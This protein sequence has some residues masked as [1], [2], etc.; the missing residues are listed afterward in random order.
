MTYKT[1]VIG[2]GSWGT[3]LAAHLARSARPEDT[4][5]LWGRDPKAI[6]TMQD[7]GINERYLPSQPLPEN[8]AYSCDLNQATTNVEL[9]VI[10]TPCQHFSYLLATLNRYPPSVRY[11]VWACKGMHQGRFP[12]DMFHAHNNSVQLG[13]D[14][15]SGAVISGPS[16]AGELVEGL[17]TATTIAANTIS[18]A[19]AVSARFHSDNFRAYSSDD[20]IGVQMA[21]AFKNVYAIAAGISDGLGFGAN[22]RSALITRGL[23]ELMRLGHA[24]GANP[25]TLTG[26]SG[27][28]DLVLTCTD[29]QS[30]NR[31][32]GLA[33]GQGM[34]NDSALASIGQV[35]E[36]LNTANE[37][38]QLSQKHGIDM[39]IVH[40]VYQVVHENKKPADAVIS[41][42]QRAPKT[43]HQQLA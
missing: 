23:A 2:A 6:R 40:E 36:G 25:A 27:M 13:D 32:F 7:T 8:L 18:T 39:P 34:D 1:C 42:L 4:V 37:A 38:Y 30:R 11:L 33:I 43:E 28:G 14:A 31:R 19:D 26:L 24:L 15:P 35:V 3:A 12:S 29:N 17:P 41:L 10:A 21:G 9:L 22:A 16:F 5:V 20:I